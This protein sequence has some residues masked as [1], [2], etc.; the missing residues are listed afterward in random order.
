MLGEDRARE[1]RS[2]ARRGKRDRCRKKERLHAAETGERGWG[3]FRAYKRSGHGRGSHGKRI[4]AERLI[5]ARPIAMCALESA[6]NPR[7]CPLL[8]TGLPQPDG[9]AGSCCWE[10][11]HGEQGTLRTTCLQC[12]LIAPT[13]QKSHITNQPR[14]AERKLPLLAAATCPAFRCPHLVINGDVITKRRP[15]LGSGDAC[16]KVVASD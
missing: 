10:L 5:L 1:Q 16:A 11:G 15:Y 14:R 3:S 8:S 7:A 13:S 2:V 4:A 12:P 6:R 9:V